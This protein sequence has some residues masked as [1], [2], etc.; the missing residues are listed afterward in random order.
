MCIT[1]ILIEK[2]CSNVK[3]NEHNGQQLCER[4]HNLFEMIKF[5]LEN[6]FDFKK[7]FRNIKIIKIIKN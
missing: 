7:N 1:D 5:I 6:I 4:I 3:L 2:H